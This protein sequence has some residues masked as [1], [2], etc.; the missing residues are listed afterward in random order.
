MSERRP[1]SRIVVIWKD[2]WLAG[3]ETFV[4]NHASGLSR[5]TAHCLGYTRLESPTA[6]PTDIVLYERQSRHSKLEVRVARMT[7]WN[8]RAVRAMLRSRA[9]VVHAH[10][11]SDAMSMRVSAKL[12]RLPLV[13]TLH[14]VD[15]TAGPRIPGL[16]GLVYR[17]K[18]RAV[19]RDADV[20][21]CVSEHIAR[22]ARHHGAPPRKLKVIYNGVQQVESDSRSSQTWDVVFVGRLVEKKGLLDL[23]EAVRLLMDEGRTIKVLV[24]GE[25]PLST[26]AETLVARHS[27]DVTFGGAMSPPD[28]QMQLLDSK[29]VAVPS[30]TARNGDTEGLPTVLLE[31]MAAARPVIATAHAG[32]PE[33]VLD[34]VTGIL[35]PE[36]DPKSI[37]Q[38]LAV[39][40][41]DKVLRDTMG[42]A[43]AVRAAS[44]FTLERQV[45]A[46]ESIY[47][48][49]AVP[50]MN[51]LRR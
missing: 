43:G 50:K 30:K 15:V 48:E 24:I 28:V 37:A 34:G 31:A 19:F 13:V 3:S 9:S 5:W 12:A 33:A 27:L 26:A 35:V 16:R 47:D 45:V 11:A 29:V 17:M 20:L 44:M 46:L 38:A 32:I 41:E 42:R 2:R 7:G 51:G 6:R 39:L 40:M 25:G 4:R 22:V 21:V 14:G 36:G 18:L 49:I 8:W 23:L 10:S 1:T